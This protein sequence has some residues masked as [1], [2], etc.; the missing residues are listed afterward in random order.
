MGM[1]KETP[2]GEPGGNT[3]HQGWLGGVSGGQKPLGTDPALRVREISQRGF[4][5]VPNDK[6]CMFQSFIRNKS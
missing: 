4:S 1:R 5:Y 6:V 2:P 3:A